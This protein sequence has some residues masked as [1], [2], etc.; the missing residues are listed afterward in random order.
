MPLETCFGA[1]FG[2]FPLSDFHVLCEKKNPEGNDTQ[3][4]FGGD[5]LVVLPTG[6]GKSLIFKLLMHESFVCYC[7]LK[8]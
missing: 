2:D 5:L 3:L 6:F 7:R 4:V 8:V 1:L